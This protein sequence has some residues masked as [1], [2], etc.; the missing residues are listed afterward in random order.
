MHVVAC[1]SGIRYTTKELIDK[2]GQHASSQQATKRSPHF[3]QLHMPGKAGRGNARH[4][5]ARRSKRSKGIGRAQPA[6]AWQLSEAIAQID[7]KFGL[8]TPIV[9]YGYHLPGRSCSVRSAKRVLT[10][11]IIA[12]QKGKPSSE[13]RQLCMRGSGIGTQQVRAANGFHQ[14]IELLCIQE[15][16]DMAQQLYDF[17]AHVLA[18][19]A[20]PDLPPM[21]LHDFT[22]SVYPERF[23]DVVQSSRPAARS[24]LGLDLSGARLLSPQA[25]EAAKDDLDSTRAGAAAELGRAF[26]P[27]WPLRSAVL[28]SMHLAQQR[29]AAD[30]ISFSNV[31]QFP[32]VHR[33]LQI[34]EREYLG[35]DRGPLSHQGFLEHLAG[36]KWR[37]TAHGAAAAESLLAAV[38]QGV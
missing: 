32:Q 7:L 18:E 26:D 28:V 33:L 1:S 29:L 2:H 31:S 25:L 4:G 27:L 12:L 34:A 36:Q 21:P 5:K 10:D 11:G 3:E 6:Y 22:Q 8:E 38:A 17:N 24:S 35:G 37:V 14:G 23:Q 19:L 15:D 20:R 30:H 9:I 13:L 16:W